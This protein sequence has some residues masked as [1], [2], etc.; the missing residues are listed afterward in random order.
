MRRM[1]ILATLV[2]FALTAAGFSQSA[3]QTFPRGSSYRRIQVNARTITALPS[4]KK[5]VVD[6]TQRGV[7]Y[8]FDPKAGQIDF[9]RV[10]VRTARGEVAIGAFLEKTFPKDELSSFKYASQSFILGTRGSRTPPAGTASPS[11]IKGFE[12]GPLYCFCEGRADC[13]DLIFDS[14]QCGKIVCWKEDGIRDKCMC[15]RSSD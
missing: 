8:E 15:S 5:Y 7:K 2:A 4:G 12:C 1:M 14:G 6:L 10:V 13:T 3:L 11:T 9:S